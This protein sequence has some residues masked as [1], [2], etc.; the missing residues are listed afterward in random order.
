MNTAVPN[1]NNLLYEQMTV[2]ENEITA[3]DFY[4]S[5]YFIN[6]LSENIEEINI[7]K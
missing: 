6:P 7:G 1:Q 3:T 5:G 2:N 4:A